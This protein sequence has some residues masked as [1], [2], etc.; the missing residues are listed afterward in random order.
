MSKTKIVVKIVIGQLCKS[1]KLMHKERKILHFIPQKLRN[2]FANGNP[3]YV[4]S[5]HH[6]Y[7]WAI[8]HVGF[9][10]SGTK[11]SKELIPPPCLKC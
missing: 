9:L 6:K 3:M 10:R 8:Q 7:R 4:V 11:I 1:A 5:S 2:S